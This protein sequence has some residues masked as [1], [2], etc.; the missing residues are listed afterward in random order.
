VLV[1]I[2]NDRCKIVSWLGSVCFL[3][4][5]MIIIGG[6]TRLSNSGLSIT[7]WKP[8]TGI[9]PPIG[10]ESW[11]AEFSKYQQ[12]PEFKQVNSTM[13]LSEFKYIYMIEFI[14]RIVA[15]FTGLALILPFIY[16]LVRGYI[17][18]KD[19][20]IYSGAIILLLLQGFMGWYMVKSGLVSNPHVSHYRLSAHLLLAIGLYSILL[21]QL[22]KNSG[23]FIL[24]STQKSVNKACCWGK[25]AV[26]IILL[27]IVFGG[28]V[29][30]LKGGF[31]YN[32]FPLMGS[33]FVPPE[34]IN[35]GF[36]FDL[37]NDPASVQFMHRII[38]YILFA[39]VCIFCYHL[40]KLD[41][42]KLKKAKKMIIISLLVQMAAGIITVLYVAPLEIALIHQLG[43]IFLL[44]FIMWANYL[45]S[46][47]K[48][49][50]NKTHY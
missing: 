30:G 5:L 46:T 7:E 25:K 21:W 13:V 6:F 24:I 19:I 33:G 3:I 35:I 28:F 15:R 34:V 45:L 50:E 47:Q 12:S 36:S 10:V 39:V 29:A 41:N 38:A 42:L 37:F 20:V 11:Q 16:F 1:K 9:F 23:E 43:A 26:F 17:K 14:H 2:N 22:F 48:Q 40:C 31:I 27:Q 18:G 32:Q 4:I 44:S 49:Y 8:V